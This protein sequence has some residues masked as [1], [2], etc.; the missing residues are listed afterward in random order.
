MHPAVVA[1]RN[2]ESLS[3]FTC[4]PPSQTPHAPSLFKLSLLLF[5]CYCCSAIS[6][7][8]RRR[9]STSSLRSTTHNRR[10]HSH[11]IVLQPSF[12]PQREAQVLSATVK[13]RGEHDSHSPPR[14]SFRM[15]PS[16][17]FATF[18][19]FSVLA[20]AWPWQEYGNKALG[21]VDAMIQ[22][23]QDSS[24]LRIAKIHCS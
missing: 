7:L 12:N 24:T 16:Q 10:V 11:S 22:R 15:R 3:A 4:Q 21:N 6:R 14:L 13:S 23:R 18:V 8:A 17:L 19:S 1:W 20:S 2:Q 5:N 9:G